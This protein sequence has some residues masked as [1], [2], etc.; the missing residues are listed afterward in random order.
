MDPPER[1]NSAGL[2]WA[3]DSPGV[4]EGSTSCALELGKN[5]LLSKATYTVQFLSVSLPRASL[6]KENPDGGCWVQ[7]TDPSAEAEHSRVLSQ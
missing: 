4:G 5:G 7:P 1:L 2:S 6:E 3:S